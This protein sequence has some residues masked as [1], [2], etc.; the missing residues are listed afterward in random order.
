VKNKLLLVAG[1]I[2]FFAEI[3]SGCIPSKPS[4]S[5]E[6]LPSERL[7]K[8]LEANRRKIKNFEG[9]GTINISTSE[10]SNKASFKVDILKPD[11]V[12]INIYGPFG[13]DLA[14]AL[15]TSGKFI[16]Y[17]EVHNIVYKGNNN[18]EILKKIFKVNL[19]FGELL[20]MFTGSVNLTPEL[21]RE[22]DKYEIAYDKYIL[23]YTEPGSERKDRYFIDIRELSINSYQLLDSSGSILAEGI[24]SKFKI[25]DDLTIPYSV[26]IQ[27]KEGGEEVN[28]DYRSI[29]INKD[30]IKIHLDIPEDAE[31]V[32][33]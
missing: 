22:P 3:F 14:S 9:T 2:I 25:I 12:F 18:N 23:T 26:R 21:S 24:F 16:F 5:V 19:T 13:I 15:V 4:E 29:E 10:M 31:V 32:Q 6:I 27:N 33:L 8:K 17:D 7:V 28:I 11:S 20:N 1:L 30:N